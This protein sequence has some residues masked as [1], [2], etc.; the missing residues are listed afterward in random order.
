MN[1]SVALGCL[2]GHKNVCVGASLNKKP[3]SLNSTLTTWAKVKE[4][5]KAIS[6]ESNQFIGPLVIEKAIE[7]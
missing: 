6:S 3:L 7:S 5:N 2:A 4:G 1:T